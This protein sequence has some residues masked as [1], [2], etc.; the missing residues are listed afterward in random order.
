L[1]L[2]TISNFFGCCATAEP[3]SAKSMAL[4][5][6]TVI[7]LHGVGLSCSNLV[8]QFPINIPLPLAERA[9]VR[10]LFAE[11]ARFSCVHN[12]RPSSLPIET[13][14]QFAKAC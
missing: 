7:F 1:R 4:R 9:R 5:V 2:I 13:V 6:R 12:R 14:S 11:S 10:G 3:Q 8:R